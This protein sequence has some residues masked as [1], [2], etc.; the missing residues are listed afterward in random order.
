MQRAERPKEQASCSKSPEGPKEN[1]T[2]DLCAALRANAK[3]TANQDARIRFL[4]N[5]FDEA[6][7][8]ENEMWDLAEA[9]SDAAGYNYKD[10][11]GNLQAP[12]PARQQGLV[13]LALQI[14]NRG[15][16]WLGWADVGWDR[17]GS[18]DV[19]VFIILIFAIY[20]FLR[21][22]VKDDPT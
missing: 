3:E 21:S 4:V 9:M 2:S 5:R 11:F 19:N 10:R 13:E 14:Y 20:F 18:L 12:N 16:G 1:D 7:A 6:Q 8:K 15:V 17:L 22:E